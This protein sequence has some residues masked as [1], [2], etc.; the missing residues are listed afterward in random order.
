MAC[1]V[2]STVFIN[3]RQSNWSNK[4]DTQ[5]MNDVPHTHTHTLYSHCSRQNID[6][7]IS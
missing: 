3:M 7:A 6:R 5:R 4:S 1:I 2:M